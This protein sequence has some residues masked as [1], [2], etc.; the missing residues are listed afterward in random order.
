MAE[1]GSVPGKGRIRANIDTQSRRVSKKGRIFVSTEKW[2]DQG[3]YGEK[4]EFVRVLTNCLGEY[5]KRV[6]SV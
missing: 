2:Q 4:I 5:R 3:Q 6:E 1:S